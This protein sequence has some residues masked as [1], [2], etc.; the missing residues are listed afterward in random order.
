[1]TENELRREIVNQAK[2]WIGRKEADGTHRVIID[3]Y[4]SIYPLPRNY[5]L[6]YTDPWCAGFVSACAQVWAMTKVVFPE[7]GCGPMVSLYK[8]HG[9]WMER[10]DYVPK[11]GDVIF[12][13][14][15]DSGSGDNTGTPDHVGLVAGVENNVITVIEGNISDAVGTRR[16]KVNARNIRGFGLPDYASMATEEEEPEPAPEPVPEPEPSGAVYPVELPMLQEGARC[17]YVAAAQAL[18]ILRGCG[19]GPDGADG[20]FGPRTKAAALAY[21]RRKG[22]EADGI[23]GPATWS[24]LLKGL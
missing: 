5:R 8:A 17:G 18:L 21:Q 3:V 16:I 12:Y 1:M 11:A 4:N 2:S 13:D 9:R 14:W 10:D 7:C 20:D 24:A 15:D 23:I 22:L 19:V 6:S